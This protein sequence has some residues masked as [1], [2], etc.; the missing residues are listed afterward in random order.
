MKILQ[1]SFAS[2]ACGGCHF[3]NLKSVE[4]YCNKK[5]KETYSH[6]FDGWKVKK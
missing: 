2:P 3:F 4:D 5:I 1:A 6:L